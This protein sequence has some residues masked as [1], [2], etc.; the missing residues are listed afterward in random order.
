MKLYS[1]PLMDELTRLQFC[2]NFVIYNSI[3]EDDLP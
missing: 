2:Y 3:P 1:I